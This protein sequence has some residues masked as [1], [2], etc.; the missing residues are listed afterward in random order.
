MSAT[1]VF[2][3]PVRGREF[4]E[5]VIRDNLDLGR[6]DRVQLLFERRITKR[7]PGSFRTRVITK[8]VTPS[9]RFQYKSCRVKQ[10]FKC[11]RALR[12][13]TVIND[14]YDF[15]VGRRLHNLAHL[16]SI[17]HHI[18]HRLLTLERT[19]HHCAVASQTVEQIVLPTVDDE[20]RAPALRWGDP[21]TMAIFSALC[22]FLASPEGFS[23]RTLRPRIG[24]LFEVDDTGYTPAR[25]TYDL[26]RLRLKGLIQR[27]PHSHR[28]MLTPKGRRIAFFMTKSYVRVVRPTL[29]RLD[30]SLPADADTPLRTAWKL[31]EKA[32][33]HIVQEARMAA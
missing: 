24:A 6:P 4:F 27:V 22:S 25:M 11:D 2:D 19:A 20:Q 5:E 17:G 28:Y 33:D 15:K 7:T 21:R 1:Q 23:N 29:N 16:R 9:I 32:L 3:R 10:Y 14:T 31:C 30:P 13:Q 18:N 26:R 8:G 12:T